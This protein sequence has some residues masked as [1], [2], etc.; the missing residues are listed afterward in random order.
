MSFNQ[1]PPGPYGQQPQQPGPYGQ[2]QQPQAPQPGYGYPQQGGQVPGQ[3]PGYGYPQ[4]A[5]QQGYGYPQQG[6]QP[7][8]GQQAP[9]GGQQT[10]YGTIPQG[11]PESGGNGKK[12]GLIAGAVAVVAAIGVGAYFAFGSGGEVKPY[13]MVLPDSLLSG[14]YTKATDAGSGGSKPIADDKEAKAM[15]ITNG[16]SVDA[17]YQKSK[18]DLLTVG[19]VYGNIADPTGAVDK[20][21]AK[22]DEGQK[23][24]ESKAKVETVTPV[25][26]YSPDGFDG[27]VMKCKAYKVSFTSGTITASGGMSVCIWGDS[28]AVGVVMNQAIPSPSAPSAQAATAEQLSE[29]TSKIRNEVRKEK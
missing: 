28:S 13:T 19:G 24:S 5:P 16:T 18:A 10:P 4:Q 25:T 11:A 26:A 17:K 8:Y 7:G 27:E 21:F 6:G 9:Y 23:Q 14:Q 29:K 20:M 12:I 2:P 3:Q 15:G 1:P 22:I